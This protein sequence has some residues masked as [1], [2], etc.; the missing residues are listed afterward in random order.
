VRIRLAALFVVALA[1]PGSAIG[2][3]PFKATLTAS[4]H[5]PKVNSDWFYVVSVTDAHGKLVKATVTTQIVDP[6]GGVHPVEFGCCKINV[7][8]H[9]FTGVFGDWVIFPPEAQGYRVSVRVIVKAL[10]AKRVLT[11]WVKPR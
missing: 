3:P 5:T 7:V 9:P 8:N 6:I 10:G 2:A 11:Y 1:L 4:T